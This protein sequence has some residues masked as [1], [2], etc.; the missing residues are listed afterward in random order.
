MT[1]S[2]NIGLT[3][4]SLIGYV[5]DN[6]LGEQVTDLSIL[7]PVFP[8]SSY[9]PPV[10]PQFISTSKATRLVTSTV[11][12]VLSSTTESIITEKPSIS[13]LTSITN[14]LLFEGTT[15]TNFE[16]FTDYG[17]YIAISTVDG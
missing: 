7:C 17:G 3:V 9:K 13:S 4:G 2:Y 8:Y 11:S 14:S 15:S 10:V 5:F 1:L 12:A 6:I 16:N